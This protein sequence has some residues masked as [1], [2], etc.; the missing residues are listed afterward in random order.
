MLKNISL[1]ALFGVIAKSVSLLILPLIAHSLSVEEFGSYIV[2]ISIIMLI[3]STF[4][5]GFEHSL[6]YFFNKFKAEINKKI[7][8]STQIIFILIAC[9]SCSIVISLLFSN[10][11]EHIN[12]ILIW[13]GLSVIFAYF[14]ALLKVEMKV[15][16]FIK[17][18]LLQSLALLGLI[19]VVV[20]MFLLGLEGIIY[21]NILAL[22][23][24][25]MLVY[26]FI[27]KYLVFN[28]N[29]SLL[30]KVM[31]YGLPL[32]PAGVIL[33]GSMQLDRYFILYFFDKYSLGI[34][35]FALAVVMIP[36]FLKT[37]V[38]SAIDPFIMKSFHSSSDKTSRYISSYFTLSLFVFSFLLLFL[39]AFSQ[40]IVVLIGG[41]KYLESTPYIPWL[42][43]IASL[44]SLNQYFI[45]GLN[46]SKR[47]VFILK[48]LIYMLFINVILM[49]V[50]IQYFE[51]YGVIMANFLANLCYTFYL[52]G[53]SN[54]LYPIE[55]YFKNN[56]LILISALIIF[57]LNLFLFQESYLLKT[58]ALLV[59]IIINMR[60]YIIIRDL[61]YD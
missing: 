29:I 12:I 46:F 31:I 39:S 10:S 11:V 59:F 50:L 7:L 28:F 4:L 6:N 56:T 54:N 41:D 40:E 23:V 52:Y 16:V 57:L 47:N 38:K 36:L 13:G 51:I 9:I 58:L 24:S 35:A 26:L 27:N 49:L 5:F 33:W 43:L 22:M 32:M 37:A 44:T 48:G 61:L 17:S 42:L 25:I 53:K 8:V 20:V 3:Q 19:Y 34:Y 2:L 15:A 45:Y 60:I 55:Y 30:K 1:Y 18:Q 21:A 14:G